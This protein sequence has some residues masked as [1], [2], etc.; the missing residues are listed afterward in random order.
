MRCTLAGAGVASIALAFDVGILLTH[1]WTVSRS[2]WSSAT[3]PH[4]GSRKLMILDS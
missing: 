1:S 4:R 2:I 3:A